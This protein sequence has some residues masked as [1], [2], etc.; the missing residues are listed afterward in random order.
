M[1]LRILTMLSS[2]TKSTILLVVISIEGTGKIHLERGQESMMVSPVLLILSPTGVL[3]HC[4][5]EETN[6][7]FSTFRRVSV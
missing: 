4:R 2:I 6:S 5:E 1:F 3:E 7:W